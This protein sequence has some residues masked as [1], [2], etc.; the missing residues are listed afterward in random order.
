MSEP[1]AKVSRQREH[2]RRQRAAGLCTSCAE[3]ALA[4]NER[5][6]RHY[7]MRLFARQKLRAQGRALAYNRDYAISWLR[8]V[9]MGTMDAGAYD[10][11][12]EARSAWMKFRFTFAKSGADRFVKVAQAVVRHAR[13]AREEKA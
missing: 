6:V 11:E 1:V 2:Q 12:A 4:H 5:C 10:I 3:P 7:V 13:R 9:H 8:G